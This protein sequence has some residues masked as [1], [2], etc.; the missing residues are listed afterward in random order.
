MGGWREQ[1]GTQRE[2]EGSDQRIEER[3]KELNGEEEESDSDAAWLLTDTLCCWTDVVV[4]L[5]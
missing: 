2:R 3:G 1:D 4:C 5:S